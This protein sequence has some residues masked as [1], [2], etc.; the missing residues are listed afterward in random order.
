MPRRKQQPLTRPGE[1]RQTTA[2]GLEIPVPTE[3]EVSELFDKVLV[4]RKT[5]GPKPEP[6]ERERA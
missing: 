6:S 4:K 1:P 3:R 2:K 5:P